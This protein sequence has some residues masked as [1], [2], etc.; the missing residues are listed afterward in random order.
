MGGRMLSA[1]PHAQRSELSFKSER[2]GLTTFAGPAAL[3]AKSWRSPGTQCPLC[4]GW[5]VAHG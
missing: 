4:R 1:P 3:P 5:Q 2:F